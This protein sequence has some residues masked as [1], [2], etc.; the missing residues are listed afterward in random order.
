MN[1]TQP[2]ELKL[3]D[4]PDHSR[5]VMV[6]LSALL[7]LA[8]VFGF[9]AFSGRQDYKNNTDKK[10]AAAV[11]AANKVQQDKDQ[12]A[13]DAQNKAPY[14]T[15]SGSVTFGSITF[16]YPKSWSA[17]VDETGSSQPLNA[18]FYP[19]QVPGTSGTT[20][21]AL[22]AEL[23]SDDYATVVD[24]INQGAQDG[25][26]RASAYIPPKLK[27]TPNVQVGTRFDGTISQDS[28]GNSKTGSLVVL[29]VRDKTLKLYTESTDFL[30]DFNNI[31]L[32][33]LTYNP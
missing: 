4:K 5:L 25:G 9:W 30:S 29:K 13:F 19:N 28:N 32:P 1:P 3:P 6:V 14:K 12:S 22:R 7:V 33:S 20:A 18:W 17:Y 2:T 16:S 26:L 21:Y 27:S 15:Y 8:L 11:A 24:Q 10:V 31:V 23:V